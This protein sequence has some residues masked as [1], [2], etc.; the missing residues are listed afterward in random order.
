MSLK[1]NTASG[2]SITLQEADTASNLTITV[3][4][5]S[6]TI[7]NQGNIVGTVSQSSGVPTGAIIER[8]SN[9]NGE[10]VKF[11]D[12]TMICTNSITLLDM[13]A[14]GSGT[15]GDIYRTEA[16]DWTFPATF[17]SAPSFHAHTKSYPSPTGAN[18]PFA[19]RANSSISTTTASGI[20]AIG[21]INT[22]SDV[23]ASVT[24]IGRWF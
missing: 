1:L 18:S 4:A 19:V 15:V 9:A 14:F 13:G 20:Q 10:F 12:G 8:G 24:A 3:P 16:D 7:F 6:G 11:A 17:I 5:V 2:G 23:V 21:G 22:G